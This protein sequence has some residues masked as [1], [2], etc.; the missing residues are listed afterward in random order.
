MTHVFNF[1]IMFLS[2]V[3]FIIG[4][5]IVSCCNSDIIINKNKKRNNAK[6]R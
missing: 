6:R 4:L 5:F 3:S 1:V 2:S